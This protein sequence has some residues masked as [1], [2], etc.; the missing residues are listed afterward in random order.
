MSAPIT[1]GECTFT[2]RRETYAVLL[3][4]TALEEELGDAV[5]TV[6][7]VAIELAHAQNQMVAL[8]DEEGEFDAAA[9]HEIRERR[10]ALRVRNNEA[11]V[12]LFR[13]RLALIA[14]RLEP[15][16]EVDWLLENLDEPALEKLTDALN[17]R[18]TL[19]SAIESAGS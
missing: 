9:L 6:N 12:E 13:A 7:A 18:P 16:P 8:A 5:D 10:R 17:E 14:S 3:E 4:R 15:A 2:P 11:R 19:G 1:I